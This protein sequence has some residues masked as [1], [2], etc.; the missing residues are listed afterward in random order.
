M[1]TLSALAVDALGVGLIAFIVL[2]PRAALSLATDLLAL[3]F[4]WL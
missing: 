3:L 1:D 2:R 4:C